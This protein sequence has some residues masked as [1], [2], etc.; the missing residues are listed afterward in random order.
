MSVGDVEEARVL[1]EGFF[2]DT[3]KAGLW[4]RLPNPL[5]GG[6]KP[7]DMIKL[8]REE[9]LLQ[10]I[11]NQ[12]AGNPPELATPRGGVWSDEKKV[13]AKCAVCGWEGPCNRLVVVG[14]DYFT[15]SPQCNFNLGLRHG[16]ILAKGG[17][18]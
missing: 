4:W 9:K 14:K 3:D 2:K 11:K 17:T 18:L 7:D 1:V 13:D 10:F 6:L 8:G 5:L 16:D 12:L 15:C